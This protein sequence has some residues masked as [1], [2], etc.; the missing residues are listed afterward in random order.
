MLLHRNQN[1]DI[2][3]ARWHQSNDS[4]TYQAQDEDELHAFERDFNPEFELITNITPMD[5]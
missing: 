2:R 5:T 3:V 1:N 4:L